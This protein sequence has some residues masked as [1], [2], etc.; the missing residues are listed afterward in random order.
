MQET[1]IELA[2]AVCS[3]RTLV[4]P[5]GIGSCRSTSRAKHRHFDPSVRGALIA[6]LSLTRRRFCTSTP[7]IG[8]RL[9]KVSTA[10]DEAVLAT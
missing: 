8:T 1:S 3:H 9:S 4:D 2:A 5:H 7:I 10:W 6:L